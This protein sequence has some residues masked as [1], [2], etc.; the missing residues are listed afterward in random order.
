MNTVDT[1]ILLNAT[2]FKN[3]SPYAQFHFMFLGKS[4]KHKKTGRVYT[5]L[6]V[7]S[8]DKIEAI[9]MTQTGLP[10]DT[11]QIIDSPGWFDGINFN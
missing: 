8:R 3:L 1:D 5:K 6:Q 10:T 11:Y 2:K 9:T 7:Y 4:F